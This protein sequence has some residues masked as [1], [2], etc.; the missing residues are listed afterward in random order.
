MTV[1]TINP[2]IVNVRWN[3]R[4]PDPLYTPFEVP[5]EIVN[6]T[7]SAHLPKVST[8]VKIYD[9]PFRVE[10]FN[11]KTNKT[12]VNIRELLLDKY[13]NYYGQTLFT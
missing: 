7:R 1:Q 13:L 9:N 3:Y 8:F 12:I 2:Q 10:I 11:N 5:K 6:V 4:T